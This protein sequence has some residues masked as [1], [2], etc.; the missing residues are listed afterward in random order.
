MARNLK[1]T[2]QDITE[3]MLESDSETYLSEDKGISP[4]FSHNT[5]N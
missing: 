3:L 1:L 2:V 5:Y 4:R